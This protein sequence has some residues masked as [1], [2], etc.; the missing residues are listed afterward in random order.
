MGVDVE[1]LIDDLI[2]RGRAVTPARGP[3]ARRG[4]PA[5]GASRKP[6]GPPG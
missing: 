2:R 6:S 5:F 1:Q 3:G 4:R